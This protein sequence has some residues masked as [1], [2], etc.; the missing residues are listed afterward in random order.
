MIESRRQALRAISATQAE[1]P[2][3]WLDKFLPRQL[4]K[5]ETVASGETT[6]QQQLVEACAAIAEPAA[7]R[8]F[9]ERWRAALADRP[10]TRLEEAVA[11]GR[12]AVGLGDESVI[13]TAVALH[14]TYGVPYLPGSALKGVAAYYSRNHL[15][16]PAWQIDGEAY[17]IVFGTTATAGYVTFFDGLFVPGSG[18]EGGRPLWPDVMT[19]HHPDYY[20]QGNQP[21]ADWDNPT[22]IPF[23]TATGRYLVALAGPEIWVNAAFRILKLALITLGLGAKTSS[24]YGRLQLGEAPETTSATTTTAVVDA[25]QIQVD[26]FKQRLTA[27]PASKVAGS[28]NVFVTE[29]RSL[30]LDPPHKVRMAQAILDK[31]RAA[32]REKNSSKKEWYRELITYVEDHGWA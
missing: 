4:V 26:R 18:A 28:I 3:L 8:V 17:A 13:E 12:L 23:L 6:P 5:N 19:V 21:P 15:T 25:D 31:I 2:G 7:Y 9:Y 11:L 10:D 24:G 30:E 16:N 29:W 1:H 32:G 27:L 22:P 20:Q 14:H